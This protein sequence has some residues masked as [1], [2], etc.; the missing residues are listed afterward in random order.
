MGPLTYFRVLLGEIHRRFTTV[1]QPRKQ[2]WPR[3][4][5]QFMFLEMT[6]S[7]VDLA[8]IIEGCGNEEIPLVCLP[9]ASDLGM[10]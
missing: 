5:G 8:D 3:I 1:V 7:S 4:D 6:R 2:S 10:H 9:I